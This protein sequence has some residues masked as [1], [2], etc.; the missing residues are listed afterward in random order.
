MASPAV[1]F[2]DATLIATDYLRSMLD[3]HVGS[4]I[5]HPR[6]D[7]MVIVRRVGGPR[8]NPLLDQPRIDAQIWTDS[9]GTAVDLG[10]QVRL[11]L[12]ELPQRDDRVREVEDFLGP[13]LIPD[14]PSD[15]PRCLLTVT[16]TVRGDS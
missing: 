9:D 11:L 5:P 8:L 14:P 13:T 16:F 1:A 2:P 15:T 6:L 7:P 3:V 12:L 4:R 10:A